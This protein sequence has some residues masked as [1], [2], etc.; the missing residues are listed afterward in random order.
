[1]KLSLL[2]TSRTLAFL[3]AT[4]LATSVSAQV[5]LLE[6]NFDG[7]S[8]DAATWTTRTTSAHV[9]GGV[10]VNAGS[11]VLDVG[12]VT[13]TSQRSTIISNAATI[14]PFA[15]EITL[16][17]S[18]LTV[19]DVPYTGGIFSGNPPTEV[20]PN[21][22]AWGNAFYAAV[23]R[24]NTDNGTLAVAVKYTAV[25]GDYISALG[26]TM[27]QSVDSVVLQV[28]DRGAG[29]HTTTS[30]T[31]DAMPTQITWVIDGAAGS[32][33]LE[34]DEGLPS[35]LSLN[36]TF[37]RF[38]EAELIAGSETISR[39]AVG[40]VNVGYVGE[41]TVATLDSLSVSAI[42]E[43]STYALF[44]SAFICG[45]VVLRRRARKS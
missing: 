42:P 17:F 30:F 13:S 29:N 4:A 16:T 45:F 25:G 22:A 26:L 3:A 41:G 1:M 32:W 10:S 27:R 7:V 35:A 9:G 24:A 34:L 12:N 36:G 33:S 5:T 18:G 37:V 39:V 40:G 6:D 11:V 15:N 23:G 14:N 20:A 21:P 43:P 19:N 2:S 8:V 31:I 28:V 38:N 44:A